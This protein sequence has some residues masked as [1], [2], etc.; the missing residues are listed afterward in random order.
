VDDLRRGVDTYSG[1]ASTIYGRVITKQDHKER[2]HGK[3]GMLQLQYQAGAKSFRNAARIMGGVRLTE[4]QAQHTVDVYR[5]RFTQ[6][7]KFWWTNQQAIANMAAGGGRYLDQWGILRTEHNKI[8][9]DG[10]LP[11]E[12]HN[13]R[14]EMIAFDGQEPELQ[15]VF[16]DKEKRFAKKIY[17]GM[18]TENESQWVAGNIVKPQTL[19][20]EKKYGNYWRTGEGVVLSVHDEAVMCVREDR[21]EECLAFSLEQFRTPPKWW[22]QLPVDGEGGIGNTYAEAK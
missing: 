22:P 16:D 9:M 6:V 19:E 4:D 7:R 20:I 18:I 13:L 15:W 5:N 10:F 8:V 11:L 1:F 2:Q 21:A 3:V 14:Q 17:G 12:Y